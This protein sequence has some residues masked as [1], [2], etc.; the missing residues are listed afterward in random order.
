MISTLKPIRRLCEQTRKKRSTY[1]KKY[2]SLMAQGLTN[3]RAKQ[4]VCQVSG[5][6]LIAENDQ[7]PIS[8]VLVAY[9][10]SIPYVAL[11]YRVDT[12]ARRFHRQSSL[13]WW[14][15][16]YCSCCCCC[17]CC[18]DV[19]VYSHTVSNIVRRTRTRPAYFSKIIMDINDTCTYLL[20]YVYTAPA[21]HSAFT[22]CTAAT[23]TTALLELFMY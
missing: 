15:T 20:L 6:T 13:A 7:L 23:N 18:L 8:Y 12:D 3:L 9:Y 10:N 5:K 11:Y 19:A 21:A 2:A 17:C 1:A 22:L 16:S 4:R 14:S